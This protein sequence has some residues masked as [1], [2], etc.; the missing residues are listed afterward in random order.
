MADLIIQIGHLSYWRHL[1]RMTCGPSP[2]LMGNVW[3]FDLNVMGPG[4]ENNLCFTTTNVSRRLGNNRQ[5]QILV[6]VATPGV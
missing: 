3:H 2:N 5:G 1:R 4:I 6:V